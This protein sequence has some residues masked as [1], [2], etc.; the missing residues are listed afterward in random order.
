MRVHDFSVGRIALKDR[1]D[2]SV[3]GQCGICML[4]E[5]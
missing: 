1:V 3:M 5:V 2:A 4:L